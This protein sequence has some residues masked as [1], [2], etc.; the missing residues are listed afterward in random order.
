MKRS[1]SPE[2]AG[3]SSGAAKPSAQ[4]TMLAGVDAHDRISGALLDRVLRAGG[5]EARVPDGM[6]DFNYEVP[7][8]KL[9][10]A[11]E[12]LKGLPDLYRHLT[13]TSDRGRNPSWPPRDSVHTIAVARPYQEAVLLVAFSPDSVPGRA[14]RSH[15]VTDRIRRGASD[16]VRAVDIEERE[17][18]TQD[19]KPVKAHAVVVYLERPEGEIE[20]IDRLFGRVHVQ[21]YE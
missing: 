1:I 15:Q 21:L 20:E 17:F 16:F 5:I 11:M 2:A 14:L 10:N 7:A 6:G 19:M 3:R 8:E 18:R 12:L 9:A 4:W 13:W